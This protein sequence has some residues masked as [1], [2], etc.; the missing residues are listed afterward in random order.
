MRNFLLMSIGGAVVSSLFAISAV[1]APGHLGTSFLSARLFTL[2]L[3]GGGH[4]GMH[5]FSMHRAGPV[6]R[7]PSLYRGPMWHGQVHAHRHF[8]HRRFFV[9]GVPYYDY[10]NDDS[11]WWSRRYHRWVCPSY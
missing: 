5:S 3:H 10:Y 9:A 1:A 6:V 7:G 2:A 4:M 8:R 11:C